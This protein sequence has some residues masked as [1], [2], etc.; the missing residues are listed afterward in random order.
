[1]TYKN[2]SGF[3]LLEV[4]IAV[5]VLS[6]GMLGVGAALATVHR[7]TASSYLAQQ[8]AQ[9]ASNIVDRMR[10]N[11]TAARAFAY[12]AAYTGGVVTPPATLCGPP[13]GGVACTPTQQAI[14]DLFQW[15]NTLNAALPGATANV[16]VKFIT[17]TGQYDA[18]VTVS[19]NDAPAAQ[20]MKSATPTR[21]VQLE[22]LL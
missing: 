1:M 12:N 8:S 15:E 17:L 22:T 16:D 9:L 14:Y 4:L 21:T 13:P 10:Q 11:P 20:A 2:A 6:L 3:T 7:T 5:V 18:I 19:Y